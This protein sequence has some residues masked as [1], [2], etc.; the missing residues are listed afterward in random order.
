MNKSSLR[1]GA[2][3][4]TRPKEIK[5]RR[6]GCAM[7]LNAWSLR[8]RNAGTPRRLA[9]AKRQTRRASSIRE[10]VPT[11][12][13]W[14]SVPGLGRPGVSGLFVSFRFAATAPFLLPL[15]LAGAAVSFMMNS[16]G[17]VSFIEGGLVR[18]LRRSGRRTLM[19]EWAKIVLEGEKREQPRT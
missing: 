3:Y 5:K 7:A 19:V 4:R 18:S 15:R 13:R 6:H 2:V 11:S 8:M 12:D 16:M 17:V 14:S 9:S 1:K 10:S